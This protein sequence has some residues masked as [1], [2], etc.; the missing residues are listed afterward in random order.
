MATLEGLH[1][2]SHSLHMHGRSRMAS[3]VSGLIR[4][5]FGAKLPPSVEV[6]RGTFFSS[7]GIGTVVHRGVK[8]GANCIISSCV[9]I[10]SR[11]VGGGVPVIEDD[12]FIGAGARILGPVR[13]GRGS[14]VGANAVVIEDVPAR[15]V[16]AG[17]PARVIRT[18]IDV[19]DFADMTGT[20]GSSVVSASEIG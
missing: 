12:C 10:G 3:C 4:L 15:C 14:V 8:I 20:G 19:G 16:V 1:S 2:V 7:G 9:S 5:G 17:V 18:Q 6:G 13:V 11:G